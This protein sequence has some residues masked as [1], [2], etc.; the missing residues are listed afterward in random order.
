[1]LDF[2]LDII[3]NEWIIIV[4]VAI[5][6]FLGTKRLPDASR[7]I[8][9]IWGEYSKTK[10][11]VQNELRKATEY[12]I[13]IQGPVE[14][15]RQKLEAMAKSLGINHSNTSDEELKNMIASKMGGSSNQDTKNQNTKQT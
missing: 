3:G 4:F 8:G 13:S 2:S 7:K 14:N 9:K 10:N 11:M 6:L 15:E 12:N 5:I 1:M